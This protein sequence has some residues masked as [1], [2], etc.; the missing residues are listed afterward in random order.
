[1]DKKKGI[2]IQDLIYEIRGQKVILDNDLASLY[3]VELR[4]LNQAVK[5]NI[6]RFPPDFMFQLSQNEWHSLRS[7]FVIS[8]YRCLKQF[9]GKTKRIQA[10]WI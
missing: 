1:M 4:A 9:I 8:N 2:N 7:H 10:N 6:R 5:R 3:G